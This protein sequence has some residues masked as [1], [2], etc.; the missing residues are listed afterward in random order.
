MSLRPCRACQH[1]VDTS[2]LACPSCGATDPAHKISRQLRNLIVT[3]IQL[4]VFAIAVV[5]AGSYAWQTYVPM[6]KEILAKQQIVPAEQ[7]PNGGR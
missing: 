1:Q 7:A 6:V 2:A 3:T 5:W 4:V